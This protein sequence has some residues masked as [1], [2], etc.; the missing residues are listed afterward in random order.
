[1]PGF[2]KGRP[3]IKTSIGGFHCSFQGF[4]QFLLL[5]NKRVL[6]VEPFATFHILLICLFVGN[7]APFLY[8][9]PWN[10]W[11]LEPPTTAIMTSERWAAATACSISRCHSITGEQPLR[12]PHLRRRKFGWF[13]Q[14][15]LFI[16]FFFLRSGIIPQH[17]MAIICIRSINATF[18]FCSAEAKSAHSSTTL[19]CVLPACPS[20]RFFT[21]HFF[22]L[23][24]QDLHK[25]F[26]T[27]P[28]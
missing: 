21:A 26:Q 17:I 27:A 19:T 3:S 28:I 23:L 13:H 1:M 12:I 6:P 7:S 20:Y 10:A 18:Y 2:I 9:G 14:D 16:F 24:F 11:T 5:S 15:S 22:L 4:E 8:S 25:D